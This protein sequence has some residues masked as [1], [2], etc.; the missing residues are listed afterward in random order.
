MHIES[1]HGVA[2][3]QGHTLL[4]SGGN[5]VEAAVGNNKKR[6]DYKASATSPKQEFSKVSGVLTRV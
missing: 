3:H 4:Q 2:L 5:K 1:L 6:E